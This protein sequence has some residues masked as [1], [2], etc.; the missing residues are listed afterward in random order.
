MMHDDRAR[1]RMSIAA[2]ARG[3]TGFLK[4]RRR[5]CITVEDIGVVHEGFNARAARQAVTRWRKF[6]AGTVG[7]AVGKTVRHFIDGDE[8]APY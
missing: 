6:A 3:Q 8:V 7:R 1:Q 4:P 5:H 2:K